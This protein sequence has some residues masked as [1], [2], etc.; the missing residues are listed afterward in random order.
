MVPLNEYEARQADEIANWKSERPSLVMA[1]FR[2]ISRP[3]SRLLARVVPDE[4]LRSVATTAEELATRYAGPDEIV[5]QAGVKDL[6][7][8]RS[9]T[10]E[11]CDALAGTI[12]AS[13]ERRAMVE[14]A[15]AGLGGIVTETL[16]VPILL[17]ATMRSIFRVGH[18]YGFSLDS[19]IDRLFVLG[20]LELSTA[21]DPARRQAVH[22]QLRDLGTGGAAGPSDGKAIH[23]DGL[24]ESL[25]GDLAIGAVP[26]VGDVT[27]IMMDYDFIRR[28][29]ITA[30]RVFQERWLKDRGKLTEIFPA[31]ASRRRSSLRGGADLAAQ[32]CYAASYGIAFGVTIPLALAARGLSSFENPVARGARDGA[33]QASHDADRFLAGLRASTKSHFAEPRFAEPKPPGLAVGPSA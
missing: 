25:L 22:Q 24:E 26:L 16:N 30:R 14:G 18:C 19:E 10:L 9:W 5:H 7:E 15:L 27:W 8:L 29:D 6:S 32:L 33:D 20:I 3:L 2:G 13:A 21:D 17:A 28:V 4:T 31:Q 1:A 23:L 11:E 12:S